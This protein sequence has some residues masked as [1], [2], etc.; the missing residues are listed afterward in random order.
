MKLIGYKTCQRELNDKFSLRIYGEEKLSVEGNILENCSNKKLITTIT[1]L[2]HVLEGANYTAYET[3]YRPGQ[4]E[5]DVMR[6]MADLCLA[7][8]RYEVMLVD[9]QK[10]NPYNVTVYIRTNGDDNSSLTQQKN[11]GQYNG[12]KDRAKKNKR[13]TKR[14]KW[15]TLV[16]DADRSS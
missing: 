4:R 10:Q 14:S 7:I 12:E 5:D 8:G 1:A 11:R 3:S 9:L 13:K 16:Q 6:A 2:I 15:Q